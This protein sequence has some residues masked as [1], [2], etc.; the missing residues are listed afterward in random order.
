[1]RMGS[2][3]EM[4]AAVAAAALLVAGCG[5]DRILPLLRI[6]SVGGGFA[7]PDTGAAGL[8]RV[9]LVNRDTA[10]HEAMLTRLSGAE[11]SMANY[12]A[13]LEA[14]DEFP[15]FSHDVGGPTLVAP[16]DSAEVVLRLHPGPHVILSWS[17]DD[18]LAG[19]AREI[20][21]AGAPAAGSAPRRTQLVTLADFT[22]SPITARAGV[23]TLHVVN[24]G[25]GE[26]ELTVL[27]LLPGRTAEDYYAWRAGGDAGEAPARP[28]AGTS[29]LAPGAE[30]WVP[31]VWTQGN[32][33]I[34][35][36]VETFGEHPVPRH[37]TLGMRQLL[38]VR[39]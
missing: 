31:V 27:R 32:Y 8:V 7:A 35:C 34:S 1:M 23:D 10:W 39:E 12:M 29:A 28:V 25:T 5:G 26:H 2:R 15:D 36:A 16:G 33:L 14:G 21:V 17:R 18:A 19:F 13:R 20:V 24:R 22:I 38:A 4:V 3:G 37:H 30:V 11:G 9:R 6:E